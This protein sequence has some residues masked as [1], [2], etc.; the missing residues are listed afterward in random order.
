MSRLYTNMWLTGYIVIRYCTFSYC[1]VAYTKR[2]SCNIVVTLMMN[3]YS[4]IAAEHY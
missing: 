3:M 4:Y 2:L 1:Q